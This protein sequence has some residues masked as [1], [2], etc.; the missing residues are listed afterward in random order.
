[1]VT[2]LNENTIFSSVASLILDPMLDSGSESWTTILLLVNLPTSR[3]II[4]KLLQ[5]TVLFYKISL[6]KIVTFH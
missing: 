6:N 1:M 4:T 3:I 2:S 5:F